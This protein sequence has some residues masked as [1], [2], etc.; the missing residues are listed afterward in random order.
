MHIYMNSDMPNSDSS[1]CQI[2]TCKFGLE[3]ELFSIY[4][5]LWDLLFIIIVLEYCSN[6]IYLLFSPNSTL[7]R[8]EAE[9]WKLLNFEASKKNILFH[10]IC[11]ISS[12]NKLDVE[13]IEV[14]L[15][16][17]LD[18]A[19]FKLDSIKKLSCNRI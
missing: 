15:N 9:G 1:W 10:F 11:R 17:N 7:N 14:L 18:L 16:P 8:K 6:F 3:W 5:N 12:L 4:V 13:I 2:R 19:M